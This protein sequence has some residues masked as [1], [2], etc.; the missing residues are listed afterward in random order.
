MVSI[1]LVEKITVVLINLIGFWLIF[2]VCFSNRKEKLNQWFIAMTF[3]VILWIDFAFLGYS[4]NNIQNA[5]IFYRLNWGS[6]ALFLVCSFYFYFIHFLRFKSKCRIL[7]QAVL[8]FGIILAT[9]SIFTNFIIKD[10][11]IE[12][13]GAEIIFGFGNVL[14]NIYSVFVGI[15]I[16]ISLIKKYFEFHNKI[17]KVK[18][19]YFLLGTFL[20]ISSNII[21]NVFFPLISNSVVYQHFG[22]YSAIILIGFTAYAI[23]KHELMGIKTLITQVLIAAILIIL[24]IDLL[25]LTDNITMQLLK[26]GILVAFLY[27]SRG[28]IESVK[29][30]KKAR[31]KLEN[32]YKKIDKYV[33]KLEDININLKEKNEDLGVLLE[34]DDVIA[35]GTLDP[36]KIAQDVVDSIPATLN[37]LG[38]IGGIITFYDKSKKIVHAYAI[39]ES[40]IVKKAKKLLG[41]SLKRHSEPI[42]TNN[43]T[44]KTIKTKKIQIGSRLEDFIAPTVGAN[45]CKMIQKLVKAKSFISIPIFSGGRIMGTLIFVGVKPEKKIIR[46]DRDI[47]SGFSSHIGSAIENAELYEKTD[48]QMKELGR[49]NRNLKEANQKLKELLEMKNEFL[50][51]VSHQLRTPLTA[52]RGMVSMWYEGS[53]DNLS[54]K[55]NKEMLKSIYISAERLNN[56][57]NDMLDSLELEGGI[58]EFKF[59]PVSIEKVIKESINTLKFNYDEKNLYINFKMK[60]KN[61]PMIDAELKYLREVFLNLIDNSCKYTNKGGVDISVG[62]SS[63]YVEIVI[64]DTGMGVSKS[65]QKRIFQKFVRSEEAIIENVAGSGLGLFIVEKIIKAHHGKIKFFSEGKGKGSMVKVYLPIKQE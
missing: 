43:L 24:I 48:V 17:Q 41:K 29:K 19:K 11:V 32:T 38:Y 52:I 12:L 31:E 61:M 62:K 2:L 16:I 58:F 42:E 34:A 59:K 30:E 53:F 46:R 33:A 20:F 10:A 22:D 56:I 21:F 51:I 40:A 23:V 15:I 25:L 39:T 18:I 57:T 64:K 13:W 37:H 5:L 27:F 49:L 45:I 6:V 3:F 1:L 60:N 47:L 35:A 54:K 44:T 14:F 50:H 36:K 7:E 26:S 65:D 63:R 4:A 28:M 8:F 55:K 9:F